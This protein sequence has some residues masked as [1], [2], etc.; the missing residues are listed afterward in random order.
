MNFVVNLN[1]HLRTTVRLPIRSQGLF[2]T[3]FLFLYLRP[4]LSFTLTSLSYTIKEIWNDSIFRTKTTRHKSWVPDFSVSG[5][6]FTVTT[7]VPFSI[8]ETTVRKTGVSIFVRVSTLLV[9]PNVTHNVTIVD[10]RHVGLLETR[11]HDSRTQ[12]TCESTH[13]GNLVKDY[14]LRY[15]S[16][17]LT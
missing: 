3:Q 8:V 11:N 12:I 4:S 7:R 10:S 5:I 13:R 14:D 6:L 16:L 9:R 15:R 1:K 2:W 17:S